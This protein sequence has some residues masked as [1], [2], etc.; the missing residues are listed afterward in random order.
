[1]STVVDDGIVVSHD[2]RGSLARRAAS[3]LL[4]PRAGDTVL[5]ARVEG[6]SFVLA[7]LA[8]DAEGCEIEVDG[9]LSVR[10]RNGRVTVA[11]DEELAL[12]TG[13]A[14][15]ATG[16]TMVFAAKEASWV[17]EQLHLLADHLALEATRIRQA[18]SFSEVVV[19][20]VK[21]TLGRS[22]RT[23]RES[24]HVKAGS[25][26]LS[27]RSTLRAHADLA[28]VTA[29]KLVKLNADQIHLG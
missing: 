6:Q 5:V 7:V 23:I 27:L 14:L 20:S 22:Y 28:V 21:E 18:A 2:G 25:L 1:M 4:A 26:T 16:R 8:R 24:E 19:E 10:A 3:C 9:N 11:A 12:S 13:G 29:K 15:R 17:A